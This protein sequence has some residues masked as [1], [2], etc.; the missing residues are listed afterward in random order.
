MCVFFFTHYRYMNIE[1]IYEKS[2]A[3]LSANR[4]VTMCVPLL[5]EYCTNVMESLVSR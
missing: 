4:K 5:P 2:S 1:L 3:N